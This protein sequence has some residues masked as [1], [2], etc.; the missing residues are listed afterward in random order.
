[1]NDV[2]ELETV[3]YPYHNA[4]VHVNVNIEDDFSLYSEMLTK[5]STH[6]IWIDGNG[7]RVNIDNVVKLGPR[8][9]V[10]IGKLVKVVPIDQVKVVRTLHIKRVRPSKLKQWLFGPEIIKR[11]Y[12]VA[13]T[14]TITVGGLVKSYLKDNSHPNNLKGVNDH[15]V[16]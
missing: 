7:S 8:L 14:S 6:Y 10:V 15:V 13:P 4:D 3:I 16:C 2:N 5:I 9:T 12:I 1:M 11:E